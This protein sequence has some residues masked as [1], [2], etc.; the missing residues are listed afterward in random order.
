MQDTQVQ[1]SAEQS[2]LL[3]RIDMAATRLSALVQNLLNVSRIERGVLTLALEQ[4][5]WPNVVAQSVEEMGKPAKDKNITLTY[6]PPAT[7]IP[8]VYIDKLRMMEVITNLIHNAIAYTH[9][10]GSIHVWIEQKD[11]EIITHV[12]DTGHGIPP[13]AISHLFKKFF[14]VSG[15]LEQG[16][17]GTGLGLYICKEILTLHKGKIWVESQVGKGSTFSFSLPTV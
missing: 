8:H 2:T 13:E 7:P 3:Q 17:K 9:T 12:R 4:I 15:S 16:S 11:K 6:T 5:D 10:G 1:Y 14:R